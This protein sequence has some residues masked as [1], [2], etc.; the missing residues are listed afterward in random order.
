[1]SSGVLTWREFSGSAGDSQHG[2]V[3]PLHA[4]AGV[5]SVTGFKPAA[6]AEQIVPR[7][8]GTCPH[9]LMS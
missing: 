3:P 6:A 9:V 2:L 5:L 7:P 1:M 8:A 4:G